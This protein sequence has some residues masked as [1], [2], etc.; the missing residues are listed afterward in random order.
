MIRYVLSQQN[1][2][3]RESQ[4]RKDLYICINQMKCGKWQNREELF[5]L[6]CKKIY[7]RSSQLEIMP[8]NVNLSQANHSVLNLCSRI[9]FWYCRGENIHQFHL[10]RI[11]SHQTVCITFLHNLKNIFFYCEKEIVN[12][13]KA[14]GLRI[15]LTW[16]DIFY[17]VRLGLNAGSF[18]FISFSVKC[19]AR[20]KTQSQPTSNG[21]KKSTREMRSDRGK[22][23]GIE[24]IVNRQEWK[25]LRSICICVCVY[26]KLSVIQMY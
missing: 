24:E 17:I 21:N 26:V 23:K 2:T 4:S 7:A 25:P 9:V 15:F 13:I 14:N 12:L 11:N 8:E 10:N 1:H 16:S 5:I 20:W 22:W 6:A 3:E 19:N 18:W